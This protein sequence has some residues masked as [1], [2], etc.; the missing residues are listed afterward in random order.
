LL[1]VPGFLGAQV[2]LGVETYHLA[3]ITTAGAE[4]VQQYLTKAEW[5]IGLYVEGSIGVTLLDAANAQ[6]RF[7]VVKALL[8]RAVLEPLP[9][10]VVDTS[11][12]DQMAAVIDAFFEQSGLRWL[13]RIIKNSLAV[14]SSQTDKVLD[15]EM[16]K[17]AM[18]LEQ[19]LTETRTTG[20]EKAA[21]SLMRS[22]SS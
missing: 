14:F 10:D 11:S 8:D 4:E 7:E 22:A 15:R 6:R 17:A 9:E 13:G 16:Q 21:A 18:D 19:R 2:Q 5:P 3:V 20:V 12:T 1:L